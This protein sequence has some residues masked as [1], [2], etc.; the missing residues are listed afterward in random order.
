MIAAGWIIDRR[1]ET[2]KADTHLMTWEGARGGEGDG[3]AAGTRAGETGRDA[4]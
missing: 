4:Q 2:A 3:G 1:E